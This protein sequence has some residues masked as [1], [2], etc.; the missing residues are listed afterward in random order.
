MA[1]ETWEVKIV[2]ELNHDLFSF[3][4][5]MKD[6]W[7]MNGRWKEGGLMIELFKTTRAS[8]KFDRMIP[9]G[10]SWLMGI[11][12]HIVYVE[13]HAAM[14][15]EKSITATKLH[16]INDTI[17]KGKESAMQ[18][19]QDKSKH[20][21]TNKKLDEL[22]TVRDKS[23]T[24]KD[25]VKSA[26]MCWESTESLAEEE[27]REEPENVANKLIKTMET[28]KHEEEHVEPTL[29]T[30]NRLKILIEEFSWEREGDGSTLGTEEPK[31]QEIVYITDLEDGL[32][33]NGT[34]L[35]DK[36]GPNKKSLLRETGLLKCPP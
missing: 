7:Q 21:E 15:P 4:K 25:T 8:M 33:K 12:V 17:S 23:T 2:L 24:K 1:R 9:S 6:G 34:T 10:S 32:R 16:Q 14:E 5:A 22:K 27:I 28:Q 29:N 35:Y 36:E 11:K 19:S 31:Q 3:T 13:A 20:D 26:M 30:G 18:E